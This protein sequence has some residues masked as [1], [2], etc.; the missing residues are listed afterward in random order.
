MWLNAIWSEG[1][2]APCLSTELDPENSNHYSERNWSANHFQRALLNWN[3]WISS[4]EA[5]F[6]EKLYCAI[7]N[8]LIPQT[9]GTLPNS[10]VE[11]TPIPTHVRG[12]FATYDGVICGK[13]SKPTPSSFLS[14]FDQT[15]LSPMQL[16]RVERLDSGSAL[17]E[18]GLESAFLMFSIN[19]YGCVAADM[20]CH[21]C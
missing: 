15:W 1:R 10:N 20:G 5:S 16:S 21:G 11:H 14:L 2:T 13:E 12:Y 9:R 8:T 7:H 17:T 4:P 18:S 6:H 19:Q 3:H